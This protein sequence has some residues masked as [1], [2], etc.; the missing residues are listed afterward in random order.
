MNPKTI[1]RAAAALGTAALVCGTLLAGIPA[2]EAAPKKP[3]PAP[4]ARERPNPSATMTVQILS[5]ND[6][7]GHLEATDPPLALDPAKTPVGGAEYLAAT[8]DTLRA[9]EKNTLTVA[10]G[11]LIGGSTFLSGMFHDEPSIESLEA[12]GLD[13][14]GVGN[15]EF[16]EGTDELLRMVNGGCHP[17]DGCYFPADPYDGTDFEYLAANVVVKD[18]GET[19]LPGTTI[20]KV[21]GIDI[22]FVGMTLEATDTLVSPAGVATVDFLDEVETANAQA[23]LLKKRGVEAIVVLLHE[24]G[25]VTGGY[26]GCE[27]ISDPIVQIAANMDAEI[28]LIVSGHTHQP[29]V[30]A[31]PDPDGND[32]FVTSAADYGRVVTETQLVINRRTK[33]VVRDLTTAT[34]HLVAR[35]AVEPDAEQTAIIE[36]WDTLAGPQKERVVGTH[37]EAILGDSSGNRAIETPM[38]DVVADAILWGTDG[39]DEG[40]AQIAFM[41]VG[42]VR[43]DLPMEAKYNEGTGEITFQEAYDIAPFGNLLVTMDLTGAQIKQVLEQQDLPGRNRLALGVSTGFTYTWDDSRSQGDKVLAE[44]MMLNGEALIPDQTYRVATLNFLAQGGDQFTAFTQGT[45]L[46]GGP[47]D[48]ANLVAY[49]EANPGL[50]T[51][52]S[53]IVGL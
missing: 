36:K 51:P 6:F 41:N 32:R 48:L 21:Q 25:R 31:I 24:G 38:V 27:G 5:F 1:R 15:H 9:G 12:M 7:H 26:N 37:T 44:T 53:R 42:G 2:A 17:T 23:A 46:V 14:A 10:A 8:L 4:S 18:T 13:V 11:D 52:D 35:G 33:D 43:E 29:Y 49:F 45:N 19:L 40:G 47:E 39:A 50:T 30:C 3:A 20:R 16:D 34:N 22:G 28:D